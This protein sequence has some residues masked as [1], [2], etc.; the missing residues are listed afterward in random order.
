MMMEISKW[1]NEK[2]VFKKW[3]SIRQIYV[4]VKIRQRI[5]YFVAYFKILGSSFCNG[6]R[7]YLMR[8]F[9]FC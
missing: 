5:A 1:D 3:L 9:E 6:F 4:S 7:L 2:F 8:W